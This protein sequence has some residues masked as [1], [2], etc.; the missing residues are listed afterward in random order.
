M[1]NAL[2]LLAGGSGKRMRNEVPKQFLEI[3]NQN[4]IE[5]F[6]TNLDSKIF[7]IIVISTKKNYKEKYLKLLKKKFI[8]YNIQYVE[9]GKTRQHSVYNS[10]KYLKKN[11]PIMY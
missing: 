4:L 3:G 10:L 5:Y 7:E 2:I 1:K 9:S 8:N 11:N 6:L